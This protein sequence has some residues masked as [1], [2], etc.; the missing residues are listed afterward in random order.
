MMCE[1]L[2]FLQRD[3]WQFISLVVPC[4]LILFVRQYV[5]SARSFHDFRFHSQK[6]QINSANN[7]LAHSLLQ[8]TVLEE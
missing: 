7:Q 4:V 3:R 2:Y 8:V 6:F 1:D 5:T